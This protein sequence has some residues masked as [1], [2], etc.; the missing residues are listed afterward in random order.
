MR[1]A[2]GGPHAAL[3]WN[4]AVA[5]P[6]EY[7]IV[8]LSKETFG[9]FN[10]QWWAAGMAGTLE[11]GTGRTPFTLQ[12]DGEEEY[13]VLHYWKIIRSEIGRLYVP[14]SGQQELSVTGL[15]VVDSKWD[16]DG[17]NMIALRLEPVTPA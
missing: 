13:P 15:P 2:A 14:Q 3:R 1:K 8:L 16:Q 6:G 11:T 10:P 9:N 12:R 5:T 17:V 4:F 7:R